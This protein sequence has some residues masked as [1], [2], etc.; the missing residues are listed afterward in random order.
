MRL[1]LA[2]LLALITGVIILILAT[3]FA[4]MQNGWP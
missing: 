1:L 2:K 4:M 3:V